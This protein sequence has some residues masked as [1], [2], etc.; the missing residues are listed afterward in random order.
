MAGPRSVQE[1]AVSV[2]GGPWPRTSCSEVDAES[3]WVGEWRLV[4]QGLHH[5]SFTC[6]IHPHSTSASFV[7]A[8]F[9]LFPV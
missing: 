9:F 2:A 1:G 4:G 7:F 3:Q 8:F 6:T 5:T